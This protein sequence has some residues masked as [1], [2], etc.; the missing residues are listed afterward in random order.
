MRNVSVSEGNKKPPEKEGHSHEEIISFNARGRDAARFGICR[1]G[2]CQDPGETGDHY[3]Q[4]R[5]QEAREEDQKEREESRCFCG[6]DNP[7]AC[8]CKVTKP[9]TVWQAREVCQ[10]LFFTH[11]NPASVSLSISV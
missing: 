11:P 9:A 7:S 4:G 6:E 2:G 3:Y 8:S 10:T 5:Y 1:A